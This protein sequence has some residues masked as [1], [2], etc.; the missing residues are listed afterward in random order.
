MGLGH[1]DAMYLTLH[2][3]GVAFLKDVRYNTTTEVGTD[4]GIGW[5][6]IVLTASDSERNKRSPQ[7]GRNEVGVQEVFHF[8]FYL[9]VKRVG[10]FFVNAVRCPCL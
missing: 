8:G 7:K 6:I 4:R 2:K 3:P 9:R 1:H 10:V 5:V